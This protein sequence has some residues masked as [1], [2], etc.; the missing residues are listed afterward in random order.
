MKGFFFSGSLT[1]DSFVGAQT[2]IKQYF[3]F[4]MVV[5]KML[6][7]SD[8]DLKVIS[9]FVVTRKLVTPCDVDW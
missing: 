9:A 8:I 5:F 6:I 1:V 2:E 7:L 4:F 3:F